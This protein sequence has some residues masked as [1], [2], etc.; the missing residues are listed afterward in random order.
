MPRSVEVLGVAAQVAAVGAERVGGHAALDRSGDRGS[1]EA[2]RRGRG[3]EGRHDACLPPANRG[4]LVGPRRVDRAQRLPTSRPMA[5]AARMPATASEFAISPL[6]TIS[7]RLGER[8]PL[9]PSGRPPRRA[10]RVC[11]TSVRPVARYTRTLSSLKP[12]ARQQVDEHVPVARGQA[13]LLLEF[14]RRG[15]VRAAR[16]RRRAGRRAAPTAAG[17]PGAGTGRPARRCRRRRARR[18]RPRRSA[19]RPRAG[20]SDRRACAPRRRAARRSF[21]RRAVSDSRRL[22]LVLSHGDSGS[23]RCESSAS[24]RST[25]PRSSARGAVRSL[26]G[27]L[28]RQPLGGLVVQRRAD[29]RREQR[30]RPGRTALELR[31]RLRADVERV[32]V[33]ARTRRTRRGGRRA[34]CRRT[35]GRLSAMLL[36]VGVVDLVAVAVALGHLGG[37]VGLRH[38]AS[39]ARAPPGRHR[40]AWCRPGRPRRRRCRPDRPSSRSPGRGVRVELGRVGARSMPDRCGP[41]R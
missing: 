16:R 4:R 40:G 10:P 5:C 27:D 9:A 6:S 39:P 18:P 41:P 31:V 32:D 24:S 29:E 20:R 12:G 14:A 11:P 15:D 2:G 3:L 37:A 28:D 26:L 7:H 33:A 35:A 8:H 34:R 21:R 23:R 22:E 38:D 19:R 25:H 30:M 1:P 17:P 13:G 36:A